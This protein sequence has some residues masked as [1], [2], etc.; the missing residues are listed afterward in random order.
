MI[1]AEKGT[2]VRKVERIL[3]SYHSILAGMEN[4]AEL[5]R[6]GLGNLF[7]SLTANY[8]TTGGGRSSEV[9]K[10]TEKFGILRAEKTVQVRQI[11]RALAS[12]THKE[13]ELIE[14]KYFDLSMPQDSEVYK[15]IGLSGTTYY[16][17]KN[18]ALR[19]VA[20][21]LNIT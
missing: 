15:G 19:K 13:R 7:P 14:A 12:L 1:V 18:Q 11:S 8:N 2:Y 6:E 20:V 10:P 3:Y 17:L 9:S 16:R 5:E 4:E 21:A